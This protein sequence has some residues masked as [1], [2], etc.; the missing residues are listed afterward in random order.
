MKSYAT[1]SE[2]GNRP[3]IV[4]RENGATVFKVL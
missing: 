1:A 4:Q 2:K 3:Y